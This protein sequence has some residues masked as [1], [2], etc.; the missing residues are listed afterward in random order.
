MAK[1][2]CPCIFL[3]SKGGYCA[4]YPSNSFN[5]GLL[6]FGDLRQAVKRQNSYNCVQ[7][8][9]ACALKTFFS[10]QFNNSFWAKTKRADVKRI[11]FFF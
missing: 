7:N 8:C 11:F 1:D 9:I 6:F 4:Y 3:K 2:K 10:I 5:Q